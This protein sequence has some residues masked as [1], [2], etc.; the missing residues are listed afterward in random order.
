MGGSRRRVRATRNRA[1]MIGIIV[2]KLKGSNMFI[3][4]FVLRGSDQAQGRWKLF[5]LPAPPPHNQMRRQMT[6]R[7][8]YSGCR[9]S[10]HFVHPIPDDTPT[11]TLI[12]IY[13]KAFKTRGFNYGIDCTG[14]S[15]GDTPW[16][17]SSHHGTTR[18]IV[19][20]YGIR[21]TR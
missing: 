20:W 6:N 12:F 11:K 7:P 10:G 8:K 4:I 13:P 18:Y 21:P 19:F 15:H 14:S 9:S 2:E 17:R 16:A 3:N 5:A 1:T